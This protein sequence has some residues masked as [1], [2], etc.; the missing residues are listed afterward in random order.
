MEGE[1]EDNKGR[2]GQRGRDM[3]PARERKTRMCGSAP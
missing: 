3:R 1:E 2:I